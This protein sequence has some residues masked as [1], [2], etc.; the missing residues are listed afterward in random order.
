MFAENE[1]DELAFKKLT[2]S[3]LHLMYPGKVGIVK[4]LP[5]FMET[6]TEVV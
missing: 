6:Q 5:V 4:K 3:D 1:V 2:E